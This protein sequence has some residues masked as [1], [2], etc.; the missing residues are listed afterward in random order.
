M[1]TFTSPCSTYPRGELY[2]CLSSCPKAYRSSRSNNLRRHQRTCPLWLKTSENVEAK[3]RIAL[4]VGTQTAKAKARRAREISNKREVRRRLSADPS[5][6]SAVAPRQFSTPDR[7][8]V[9]TA[10]ASP[11]AP[12]TAPARQQPPRRTVTAQHQ[13]LIL[14]WAAFEAVPTSPVASSTAPARHQPEEAAQGSGEQDVCPAHQLHGVDGQEANCLEDALEGNL[15]ILL[16]AV[17]PYEPMASARAHAHTSSSPSR[18]SPEL[19]QSSRRPLGCHH[20]PMASPRRTATHEISSPGPTTGPD[21]GE[22]GIAQN[23]PHPQ[24]TPAAEHET[25]VVSSRESPDVED[26][27]FHDYRTKRLAD[28]RSKKAKRPMEQQIPRPKGDF[29]KRGG[30]GRN[31]REAMGL[32]TGAMGLKIYSDIVVSGIHI[33]RSTLPNDTY[34]EP[35]ESAHELA[36]TARIDFSRTFSQ[37]DGER[38]AR[39]CRDVSLSIHLDR[40]ISSLHL[41][42]DGTETCYP[43]EV[44]GQLGYEG[45]TPEVCHLPAQQGEHEGQGEPTSSIERAT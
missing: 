13:S 41:I 16:S 5:T 7:P 32:N 36:V 4:E 29:I 43:A 39:F 12:S 24:T 20:G 10:P 40:V 26:S 27:E 33:T 1:S 6:S 31:I 23:I 37:Q 42:E 14:D 18:M 11:E 8:A 15:H 9:E 44:R 30:Q 34:T 17:A 35:Q 25:T 28:T 22:P 19:A 3:R 2:S 45:R 38:V 21:L